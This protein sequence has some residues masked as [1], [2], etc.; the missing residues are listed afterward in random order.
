MLVLERCRQLREVRISTFAKHL[1]NTF[2]NF[3][4]SPARLLELTKLPFLETLEVPLSSEEALQPVVAINWKSYS[5]LS[6]NL[7]GLKTLSLR[8]HMCKIVNDDKP[9]P[10]ESFRE[11]TLS[12]PNLSRFTF[13]TFAVTQTQTAS[14]DTRSTPTT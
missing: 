3:S 2:L 14:L 9:F 12:T 6:G 4:Y 13:G 11:F 8:R 5:L 10:V 1:G 7:P